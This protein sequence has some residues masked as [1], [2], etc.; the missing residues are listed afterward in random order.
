MLNKAK[1]RRKPPHN[2]CSLCMWKQYI[3]IG[4]Y[5][6]LGKNKLAKRSWEM[7]EQFNR[8]GKLAVWRFVISEKGTN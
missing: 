2:L 3:K 5:E 7:K 4:K 6:C 8:R 1:L